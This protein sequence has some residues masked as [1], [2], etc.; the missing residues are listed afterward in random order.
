MRCV[1]RVG[2]RLRAIH[3]EPGESREVGAVAL[4]VMGAGVTGGLERALQAGA[5]EDLEDICR[6][7][8]VTCWWVRPEQLGAPKPANIAAEDAGEGLSSRLAKVAR[9]VHAA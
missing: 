9:G 1:G 8:G 3:L 5:V 6:S 7:A 2:D 4:M